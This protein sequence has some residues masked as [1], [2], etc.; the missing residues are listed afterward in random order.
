MHTRQKPKGCVHRNGGNKQCGN[1]FEQIAREP[2]YLTGGAHKYPDLTEKILPEPN[3]GAPEANLEAPVCHLVSP[4]PNLGAPVCALEAPDLNLEAPALTL[5][6]PEPN[7][8]A[9]ASTLEAPDINLEAPASTF[10]APE[11]N[12]EASSKATG[13]A[14]ATICSKLFGKQI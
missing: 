3:L 7:L 1:Q 4:K 6:A 9:P 11:V 12:F 14:P 5:G 10:G 13:E 2:D 8:E